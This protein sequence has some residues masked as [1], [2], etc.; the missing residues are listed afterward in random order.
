MRPLTEAGGAGQSVGRPVP[1][2]A[3]GNLRTGVGGVACT[4]TGGVDEC[5]DGERR[6]ARGAKSRPRK[7]VQAACQLAANR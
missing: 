4:A 1:V 2:V 5:E 6:R 7:G 3:R